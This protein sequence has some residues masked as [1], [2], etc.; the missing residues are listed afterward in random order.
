M[1]WT[2]SP[3]G[4]YRSP[5]YNKLDVLD[6]Q[7]V[8]L[9]YLWN[10][11]EKQTRGQKGELALRQCNGK[12]EYNVIVIVIVFIC[13]EGDYLL[14]EC[15]FLFYCNKNSLK[16]GENEKKTWSR[17]MLLTRG[18]KGHCQCSEF[19]VKYKRADALSLWQQQ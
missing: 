7:I 2:R 9:S 12:H 6:Y 11:S 18:P 15:L 5:E 4:H 16:K 10:Q 17:K 8:W 19:N 3:W 13:H 1:F 14:K